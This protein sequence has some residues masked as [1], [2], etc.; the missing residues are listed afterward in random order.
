MNVHSCVQCVGK[1]LLD[2]MIENGMKGY[3]LGR[4]SLFVVVSSDHNLASIGV[5]IDVSP[6]RMHW[7][8]ISGRK[9][10][11]FVSSR[12]WTKKLQSDGISK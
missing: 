10:V 4:R 12:F 5:A 6:V 1:P 11:G 3:T 7:E 2:S 9:L 8:D